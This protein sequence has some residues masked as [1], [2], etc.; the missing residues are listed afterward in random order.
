VIEKSFAET[1][2]CPLA[3][4]PSKV[5]KKSVDGIVEDW[6]LPPLLRTSYETHGKMIAVAAINRDENGQYVTR[7]KINKCNHW[8]GGGNAADGFCSLIEDNRQR[9]K[10]GMPD[11][12]AMKERNCT[13][14]RAAVEFTEPWK[15]IAGM[16]HGDTIAVVGVNRGVND[17]LLPQCKCATTK[18][19]AY[20]ATVADKGKCFIDDR[21]M[22]RF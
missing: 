22:Q 21:N 7:C 15:D 8:R 3:T 10:S 16:L 5:Y 14:A 2:G 18:C 20:Y 19:M 11:D 1:L 6:H 4:M 12:A 13:F 9:F 17:E